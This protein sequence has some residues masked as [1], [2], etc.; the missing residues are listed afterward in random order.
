MATTDTTERRP[1]WQ[2]LGW[3]AAIWLA[4][5]AVL[6]AVGWMIRLVLAPS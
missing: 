5:V 2:R 4:S 3:M 6:G 1:F